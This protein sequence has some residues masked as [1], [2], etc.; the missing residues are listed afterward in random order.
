MGVQ[1]KRQAYD[2]PDGS[3]FLLY[4]PLTA[5]FRCQNDG[6]YADVDNNCQIFHICNRVNKPDGSSEMQQFSF[7]CG[8]QT[9]FN[10]LSF[11]CAFPEEAIPCQ[12]SADFFYLNSYIGVENAP[13]LSDD[14]IRRADS[15]KTGK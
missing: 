15:Y 7:L 14:D 5:S 13:F 12:S 10:Q 6:Y 3:Q 8:N 1:K 9:V 11:T 2:L 4:R